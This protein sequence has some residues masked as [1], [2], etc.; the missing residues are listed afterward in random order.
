MEWI[1]ED[2]EVGGKLMPFADFGKVEFTDTTAT[3]FKGKT[4]GPAGS[5]PIDVVHNKTVI[6]KASTGTR[7][8]TVSYVG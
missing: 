8:A 2:F 5:T 3:T 1:V 4:V 7:S 6:T